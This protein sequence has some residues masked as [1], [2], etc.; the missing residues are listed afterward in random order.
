M[1][2]GYPA[3]LTGISH[4][5]HPPQP[6]QFLPAGVSKKGKIEI[7]LFE[8]NFAEREDIVLCSQPVALLSQTD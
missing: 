4:S 2:F 5:L 3:L 6:P 8:E 1:G 7:L